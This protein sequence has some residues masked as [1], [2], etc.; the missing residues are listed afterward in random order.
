MPVSALFSGIR[1]FESIPWNFESSHSLQPKF[2]RRKSPAINPTLC[3]VC[4]Y[5]FPGF[6]S[7]TMSFTW[8]VYFRSRKS[9]KELEE[10]FSHKKSSLFSD[11]FVRDICFVFFSV[12]VW[13]CNIS[14]FLLC[15]SSASS[16]SWMISSKTVFLI[17]IFPQ[18]TTPIFGIMS[19]I[20][21]LFR[22][23]DN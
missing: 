14:S 10:Q 6:P 3:R 1:T 22:L 17:F 11:I 16:L 12:I 9:Q 8:R 15:R 18:D 7:H 13:R 2:C 20:Y 5:C 23:S 4:S 21:L 19:E